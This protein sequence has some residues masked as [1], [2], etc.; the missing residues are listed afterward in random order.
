M[1]E[2]NKEI[3]LKGFDLFAAEDW[4]AFAALLHP[5]CLLT[6]PANWPEPGPFRGREAAAKQ[7]ERFRSEFGEQH[8]EIKNVATTGDWGI[9]D[10]AWN[11]RG[12]GSGAAGRLE[13]TSATRIED[14]LMR[15]THHRWHHA[16]ALEAA[17]L[18]E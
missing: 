4:N 2:E 12:A 5:A 3:L 14:G 17:G 16:E 8:F 13:I 18:S 10:Y 7:F 9:V 6:A 15:E 1:S 11:V